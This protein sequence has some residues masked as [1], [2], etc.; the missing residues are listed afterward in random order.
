MQTVTATSFQSVQTAAN[1]AVT[2][3]ARV[4][5]NVSAVLLPLII[6]ADGNSLT[7]GFS[8][9]P[10]YRPSD[11]VV[12][13]MSI[14]GYNFGVSGQTTQQMTL[15]AAT[16]IDPYAATAGVIPI[17]IAQ[18]IF[19]DIR[20]NGIT[21]AAAVTNMQN[22]CQGRRAAGFFVGVCNLA[23]MEPIGGFTA[24]MVAAVNAE[25]AARWWTFADFLVDI[26]AAN[27]MRDRTNTTY[28]NADKTHNTNLGYAVMGRQQTLA[29]R[30]W[31]M[32]R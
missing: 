18:E 10:T 25:L 28:F 19:N 30:Q 15:D 29:I 24:G 9:S 1:N 22:Y 26:Y 4:A 5:S 20:V 2:N 11:R 14:T 31:L 16:Q 17:L 8:S 13:S 6:V 23:D 7:A 32:S 3:A 12:S 27:E 21:V